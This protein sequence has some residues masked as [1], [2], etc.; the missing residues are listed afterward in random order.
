[1]KK[2]KW[3]WMLL[4]GAVALSLTAAGCKQQGKE[5]AKEGEKGKA[6][7]AGATITDLCKKVVE[8]TKEM[9]G[10]QLPAEAE[11]MALD[12][13]SKAGDAWKANPKAKD[14]EAAFVKTIIDACGDKKSKDFMDCYSKQGP[15]AAKA[16]GA[17]K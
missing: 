3:R 5:A 2:G 9:S 4:V 6:A 16:A 11:K 15:E 1:M 7:A 14:A 12:G 8:A 13:C 10:G 17:V